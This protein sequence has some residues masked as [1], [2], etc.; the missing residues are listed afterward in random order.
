MH[1]G[2]AAR[3]EGKEGHGLG[4]G[5]R[6]AGTVW[7]PRGPLVPVAYGALCAGGPHGIGYP[8]GPWCPWLMERRSRCSAVMHMTPELEVLGWNPG[9][10][11]TPCPT[12][13]GVCDPASR[14]GCC[15]G[16]VGITVTL[17]F[18]ERPSTLFLPMADGT[19]L[20]RGLH[21]LACLPPPQGPQPALQ[22]DDLHPQPQR[23]VPRSVRI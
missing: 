5:R 3:E 1:Y 22:A 6:G 20:G 19:M 16:Q 2:R 15:E 18:G 9:G 8:V 12:R 7:V 13:Q 23:N 4:N 17:E 10:V 11:G 14:K 21:L